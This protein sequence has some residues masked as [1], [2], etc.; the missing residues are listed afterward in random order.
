MVIAARVAR[1][2][3]IDPITVLDADP[4]EFEVRAAAARAVIRDMEKEVSDGR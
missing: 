4:F 3:S 2:F 1:I